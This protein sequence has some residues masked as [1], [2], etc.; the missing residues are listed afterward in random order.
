MGIFFNW[1]G[2]GCLIA[3]IGAAIGLQNAGILVGKEGE[4]FGLVACGVIILVDVI[5]RATVARG[6]MAGVDPKAG[7]GKASV[8][9]HWAFGPA[10][11]GSLMFIPAWAT[12]VLAYI[13]IALVL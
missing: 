13:V 5:Y 7:T 3:G 8:A 11:G 9:S 2:L 10:L 12:A 1:L 4:N 6:R